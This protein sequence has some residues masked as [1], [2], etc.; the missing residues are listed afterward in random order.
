MR[1]K[2]DEAAPAPP[3]SHADHGTGLGTV[4]TTSPTEVE[5]NSWAPQ[6]LPNILPTV[7]SSTPVP[8]RL[9]H[10]KSQRASPQSIIAAKDISSSRD[11]SPAKADMSR[12]YTLAEFL[13]D[14]SPT[15]RYPSKSDLA[16]ESSTKAEPLL[17][18]QVLGPPFPT[19]A[20]MIATA[21]VSDTLS[22]IK[23]ESVTP[24]PTRTT[25]AQSGEP[26]HLPPSA[27]ALPETSCAL[28]RKNLQRVE[29]SLAIFAMDS[30]R[31]ASPV[32][33]DVFSSSSKVPSVAPFDSP[34]GNRIPVPLPA[35]PLPSSSGSALPSSSKD[36]SAFHS[37]QGTQPSNPPPTPPSN[38]GSQSPS[39]S[40]AALLLF[41]VP[42]GD[43]REWTY[44]IDNGV[45]GQAPTPQKW[46]GP[47]FT[48]HKPTVSVQI[49]WY[50]MKDA[51]SSEEAKSPDTNP[52]QNVESQ[53]LQHTS[54]PQPATN[55][56]DTI[57]YLWSSEIPASGRLPPAV[58]GP[59][60]SNRS[61]TQVTTAPP[62]WRPT[63]P[64][65]P[66]LDSP[67]D[68]GPILAPAD[69]A[70]P[71]INTT[72]PEVSSHA[73]QL[74]IN[75]TQALMSIIAAGQPSQPSSNSSASSFH[76]VTPPETEAE[77]TFEIVQHPGSDF[78]SSAQEDHDGW[79]SG[80]EF[81]TPAPASFVR[82]S[83]D[84]SVDVMPTAPVRSSGP[85]PSPS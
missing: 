10:I 80:Y 44:E 74:T 64:V 8:V 73:M 58:P 27:D 13:A 48:G 24:P 83:D 16:S 36:M 20:Q 31:G 19:Y 81:S 6:F 11:T 56:W 30:S 33:E 63:S 71:A 7:T 50:E 82:Y 42:D 65:I 41:S 59:S 78:A 14:P 55:P 47:F 79:A 45:S 40:M 37:L 60:T 34:R 23:A 57:R 29:S 25:G 17:P 3:S 22:S 76:M 38:S 43:R 39:A 67:Q 68:V 32:P 21:T 46:R 28:T 54:N 51:S 5:K 15:G 1:V 72:P 62:G 70:T 9:T 52:P 49:P 4:N 26:A 18:Q 2:K 84:E 75:A 69:N 66:L 35:W 53:Q 77:D 12:R 85:S 61:S